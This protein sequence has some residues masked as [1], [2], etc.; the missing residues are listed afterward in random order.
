MESRTL[1]RTRRAVSVV[2][3]LAARPDWGAV[4]EDQALDVLRA[5][6]DADVTFLDT[7]DVYGDG[8][9]ETLI[10]RLL[11]ERGSD[12]VTVATKMGRRAAPP[13]CR[14]RTP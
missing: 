13:T 2:G 7:A 4:S 8:R 6:L 12:G 1:G 9:S 11:A 10:G 3:L 14:R 5:A